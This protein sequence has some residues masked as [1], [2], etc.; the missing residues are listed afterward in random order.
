M[1]MSLAG[2]IGGN[3]E[4]PLSHT[5]SNDLIIISNCFSSK[6]E[7]QN[8]KKYQF[9]TFYIY[10]LSSDCGIEILK[11]TNTS[12]SIKSKM[13]LIRLCEIMDSYLEK[14]DIFENYTCWICEE[15]DK[16]SSHLILQLNEFDIDQ[17]EIPE[18]TLIRFDK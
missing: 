1:K 5:N 12:V 15:S 16:R 4:I 9:T 11:S 14:D 8:V 18:K 7:R 3:V 13:K 6:Y 10:E 2:Y 17:I